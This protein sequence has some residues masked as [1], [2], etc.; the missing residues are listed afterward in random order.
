MTEEGEDVEAL[1]WRRVVPDP[2]ATD[3]ILFSEVLGDFE[4]L[5]EMLRE[6]VGGRECKT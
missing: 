1:R 4:G 5:L 3:A 6:P 2:W